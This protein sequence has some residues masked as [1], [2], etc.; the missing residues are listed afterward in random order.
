MSRMQPKNSTAQSTMA[1]S[2]TR[3]VDPVRADASLSTR[4][5]DEKPPKTSPVRAASFQMPALVS[6]SFIDIVVFRRKDNEKILT[7]VGLE[8]LTYNKQAI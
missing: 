8:R 2:C 5:R 4:H 7:F 6:C 1:A 3:K